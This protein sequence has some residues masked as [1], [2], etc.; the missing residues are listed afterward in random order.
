MFSGVLVHELGHALAFRRYGVSPRIALTMMGG[1]ATENQFDIWNLPG[2][3][4]GRKRSP[5]EQIIIS[6]AGPF[7]GFVLAGVVIGLVFLLGGWINFRLIYG[8]LPFWEVQLQAG[9]SYGFQFPNLSDYPTNT[10]LIYA[11]IHSFLFV[12][13][14]WGILNPDARLSLGWWKHCSR[15]HGNERPA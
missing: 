14:Y 4:Y 13:I 9:Q 8:I 7:A 10:D 3:S 5:K 12:N 6:A 15:G 1:Y 2:A 11:V